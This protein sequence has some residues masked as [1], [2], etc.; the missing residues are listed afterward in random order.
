MRFVVQ[1]EAPAQGDIENAF[2]WYESRRSGLGAEFLRAVAAASEALERDPLRFAVTKA[3]YRWIK[4]RKFPYG[5]HYLVDVQE[6][7]VL[8]CLHFRQSPER[9]PGLAKV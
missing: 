8:A 2:A 1:F 6:V 7:S 9:W 4:L 5:M 3:P